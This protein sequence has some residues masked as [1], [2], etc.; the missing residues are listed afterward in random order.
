MSKSFTPDQLAVVQ[1]RKG[2]LLVIAGAGTG[3]THTITGRVLS[4]INDDGVSPESILA[5]T[6]TE[7]AAEEMHTRIVTEL[8]L[9]SSEPF[10]GTFHAFADH[11]VR[12]HGLDIGINPEF[13]LIKDADLLVFL[14]QHYDRFSFSYYR[15]RS[16]PYILLATISQYV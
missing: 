10:I 12:S 3:K 1:H 15:S 13:T 6:F 14:R 8:P 2:P 11:V 5:L 16:Q 9:G 4:L 7:K